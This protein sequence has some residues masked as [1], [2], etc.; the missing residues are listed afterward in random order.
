MSFI[1]VAASEGYK[2]YNY[3]EIEKGNDIIFSAL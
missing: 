2:C 3:K 1:T